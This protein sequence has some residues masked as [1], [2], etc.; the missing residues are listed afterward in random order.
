MIARRE[1]GR[2]GVELSALTFGTM[3][4]DERP[5][6]D[7]AWER[8]IA[9]SRD[10]GISTFHVSS[11]YA[12]HAR[13]AALAR[14]L[15]D[16]RSCQFIAKLAD[17]HFGEPAF[18]ATRL[19]HRIDVY[20]ADLAIE[21]L[22]VVQW[23]WRADL[24]NEPARLEG[25]A[26]QRGELVA[27]FHR[28]QRAGKIGAVAPFPYTAGFA[29]LLLDPELCAGLAVYLNPNERE[30]SAHLVRAADLGMGGIA[31]R[32][33]AAGAAVTGAHTARS[34]LQ[35]VLGHPGVTTAVVSYSSAKH[36]AELVEATE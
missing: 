32:P 33:L 19:E 18:D 29:D 12:P 24:K 22:D 36:L 7:A 3:R 34:C 8:L 5:L 31:I 23:M 17:P 1:L 11:E 2:S 28:L 21:R 10:A 35:M 27:V 25:V 14:R 20:L 4:L 26:T 15:P 16:R 9:A 30:M 6:D 13:F